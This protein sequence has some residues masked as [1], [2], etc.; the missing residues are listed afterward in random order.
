MIKRTSKAIALALF[1]VQVFFSVPE[2]ATAQNPPDKQHVNQ[3]KPVR[4]GTSEI[5]VDA[6]VID[7]KNRAVGDL[8]EDSFEVYE[9]G[10]KQKITSFRFESAGASNAA[11]NSGANSSNADRPFNLVSLIFDSQT[12]RDGALRARQAALEYINSGMKANDYVAVFGVDLGLLVLAPY[13]NDK[14]RLKEAV[15]AFTSRESKKYL[16]V[17]NE[18]RAQ[19]ESLVEPLSDGGR[20]SLA[21][22][23][24]V[25]ETVA[26]AVERGTRGDVESIDPFKVLLTTIN[27]SGLRTLRAFERYEREF[28]GWR[29]VAALLAIINGQKSVRA[30]RKMMMYFSEGFVV[31]PA[32]A[33]QYKSI[34][35]AANTSGVTIYAFDIAGLR[36]INPNEQAMAER[37][38]IASNRMRNSNPELVQNGVSALGRSEETARLNSV[39]TLDELSEETGGYTIKNTNDIVEGLKKILD[40]LSNHYVLTYASSNQNYNGKFRRIAVKLTQQGDFRIRARRGY[41]GLR[42]LDDS[43]ILVREAPLFERINS[44]SPIGDFPFYAHA[45][46]FRGTNSSRLVAIYTEFP[47]S[48]LKFDVDGKAKKFSSQF[49]LLALIK[50]DSNEIVRKLGQEFTLSGPLAQLEEIKQRPQIYNHLVLLPPGKYTLEAIARDTATGKASV[51]RTSFEVPEAAE[52]VLRISSIVLSRGVNPL[53]EDQKKQPA[54]HPLYLEGQAYFVPNV[55]QIFSKARDQNILIHFNVY[56]LKNSTAQVSATVTFLQDGKVFTEAG[57]ALPAADATGRILY[58]TSFPSSSF[59]PGEYDLRVTIKDG[60]HRATSTAHFV[61]EP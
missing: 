51:S 26:P 61:M 35:S 14:A 31:T 34:I 53:T 19:L 36:I 60:S 25:P 45:L 50:N 41:Y 4:L 21:D 8:T 29:S 44:P 54:S 55:G 32:V 40:E 42:T 6:V 39:T 7:K 18:V 49:A 1:V 30:A 33:D 11:G 10:V 12:T 28:Q 56:T 3:D 46:H 58:L 37:D 5:I 38:A 20:I 27:L 59:L 52:D 22:S 16:A 47:V 24:A 2:L 57:G 43:P 9:D 13:T 48:A 23:G 17:A 15:D